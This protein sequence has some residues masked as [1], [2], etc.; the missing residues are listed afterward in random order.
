MSTPDTTESTASHTAG[1][2]H[3]LDVFRGLTVAAM[4]IVNTP[5]SWSAVYPA[6]RHAAWHGCRPAD[7]V[8]PFFLFIAGVSLAFARRRGLTA[9]RIIRRAALLFGMGLLLNFF[10]HLL[11]WLDT[12]TFSLSEMRLTGVLQR[13]GLAFGIAGLAVS[14]LGAQRSAA[15]ALALLLACWGLLAGVSAPGISGQSFSPEANIAG[16]IDRAVLTP[17]HMYRGGPVDPEG[18]L[19][20]LP[21]AV[22]VLCGFF[23]GTWLMGKAKTSASS[24]RL[25]AAG[26]V[27]LGAG[28]LWGVWL[29][30]N[31]A[32]WTG[33]FVLYTAGAA[34]FCLALCFEAVEVRGVRAPAHPF[35]VLGRNAISA[36]VASAVLVRVLLHLPAGGTGETTSMY[37][38]LYAHG[39]VPWAGAAAGSL[40]F[41]GAH[42][43]LLT[44]VLWILHCR[45]IFIRV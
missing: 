20:T 8:F 44:A 19:S 17:E 11:D 45:A 41:A 32:L 27:L 23:C 7:L 36:Y 5:G 2:L 28:R 14:G 13:I 29:P 22:T 34:L 6:L 43:A 31:K 39:F 26:L 4:I 15:A 30:L 33:S 25:A 42:L 10:P 12:G 37:S 18:L 21:A 24:M 9:H 38:W 3:S 40:A 1:R 35:T 16:W